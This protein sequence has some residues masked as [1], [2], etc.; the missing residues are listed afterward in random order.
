MLTVYKL[1]LYYSNLIS[2]LVEILVQAFYY[3]YF[4]KHLLSQCYEK[5]VFHHLWLTDRELIQPIARQKR[6]GQDS[7]SRKGS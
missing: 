7:Q 2:V 3:Y 5:I 4:Y 1:F 6:L